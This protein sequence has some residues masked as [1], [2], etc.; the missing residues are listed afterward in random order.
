MVE[1]VMWVLGKYPSITPKPMSPR[2]A[3]SL[4]ISFQEHVQLDIIRKRPLKS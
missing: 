1:R 2:K 4:Q 3:V